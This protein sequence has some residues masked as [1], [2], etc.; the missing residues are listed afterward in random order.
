M[1]LVAA[2]LEDTAARVVAP[3]ILLLNPRKIPCA[4]L[5]FLD[6]LLGFLQPREKLRD[7]Q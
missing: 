6:W 2:K 3:P 4:F 1:G 7:V 5:Q